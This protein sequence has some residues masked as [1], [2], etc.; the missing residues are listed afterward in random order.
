MTT[1]AQFETLPTD[2]EPRAGLVAVAMSG[3]VD[4]STVAALLQGQARLVIGLTIEGSCR[5]IF[6]KDSI[7]TYEVVILGELTLENRLRDSVE[8]PPIGW[9]C[10]ITFIGA[11]GGPD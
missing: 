8:H 1:E 4:S 3:G 9:N 11:V 6:D 7:A 10:S 5:D 2:T